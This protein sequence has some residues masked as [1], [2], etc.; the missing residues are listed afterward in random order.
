MQSKKNNIFA[1]GNF[2][3][4]SEKKIHARSEFYCEEWRLL[5]TPN[6]DVEFS[7]FVFIYLFIEDKSNTDCI[8]AVLTVFVFIWSNLFL[9]S[10]SFYLLRLKNFKTIQD[11]TNDHLLQCIILKSKYQMLSSV[12]ILSLYSS[13]KTSP[14]SL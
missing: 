12:G 1:P 5:V 7:T 6:I 14:C 3:I 11:R 10:L 4:S 2:I 9:F 13:V 8:G